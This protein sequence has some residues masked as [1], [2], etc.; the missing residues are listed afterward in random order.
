M[1]M[2]RL[3]VETDLRLQHRHDDGSWRTLEPREPHSPSDFDPER[4]W[5]NGKV[6]ACTTCDELVRV[7]PIEEEPPVS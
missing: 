1:G 2:D 3:R 7:A 6:Y 4:E 5:A